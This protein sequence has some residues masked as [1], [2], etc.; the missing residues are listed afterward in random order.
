MKL[1]I[2]KRVL[3]QRFEAEGEGGFMS[4]EPYIQ[5]NL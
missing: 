2:E 1:I 4:V 5:C 3:R